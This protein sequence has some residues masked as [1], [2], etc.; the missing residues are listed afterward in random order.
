MIVALVLVMLLIDTPVTASGTGNDDDKVVV[1]VPKKFF[2][3]ILTELTTVVF[4]TDVNTADD[5]LI[6]LAVNEPAVTA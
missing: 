4:G 6:V 5:E 2:D 1:A 3:T